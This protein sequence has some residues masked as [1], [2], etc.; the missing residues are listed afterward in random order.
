MQQATRKQ[1]GST[2]LVRLYDRLAGLIAR[3]G[4]PSRYGSAV[5]SSA[6]VTFVLAR[7]HLGLDQANIS[8]AYL[9]AVFCVAGVAGLGPGIVASLL[10]LLLY[11]YS[12]VPPYYVLAV[13]QPQDLLRLV[14]FLIAALLASSMAGLALERAQLQRQIVEQEAA[15]A[16]DRFKA[17][18]LSSISHDL[19]TPLATITGVATALR[20][21]TTHIDRASEAELLDTLIGEAERL[22]RLVGNLLEMS[23]IESGAL[24]IAR[25]WEEIGDL[26]G[27]VLARLRPQLAGRPVRVAM[28]PELPAIWVNAM[29]I[30]QVLTNLLENALKYTPAGTPIL[31]AAAQH[32]DE[33]WVTVAD[34]GP[35]IPAATL[36]TIFDKFVRVDMVGRA[37][38]GTGLGLAICKGIVEAHGGR[39]WAE[40]R[41]ER[42]LALTFTLPLRHSGAPPA[43]TPPLDEE[44]CEHSRARRE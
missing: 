14:V 13:E 42:G 5:L 17:T 15:A 21:S 38:S 12:F 1:I 9:L 35:G 20:H 19:R 36:P 44:R 25:A 22:N 23:R 37:T 10:S 26:T 34:S 3:G 30:D 41:A 40:N 11:N 16:A 29:L 2:P 27:G 4:W 31:L 32:Q 18:V 7:S 24:E 39:I 28:A 6:L 8:L 43:P 33:L